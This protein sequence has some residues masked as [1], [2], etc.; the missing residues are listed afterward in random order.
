[1]LLDKLCGE[2][3]NIDFR[4]KNLPL[5]AAIIATTILLTRENFGILTRCVVIG[6]VV[7]V[8]VNV[9]VERYIGWNCNCQRVDR[10]RFEACRSARSTIVGSLRRYSH[11]ARLV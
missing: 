5:I 9:V 4:P 3:P 6:A 8:V 10:I 2:Y 11:A 1:M 7:G